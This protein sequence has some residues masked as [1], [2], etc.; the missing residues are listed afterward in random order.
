MHVP[1]KVN[2]HGSRTSA[3]TVL[4]I[5]YETGAGVGICARRAPWL[6]GYALRS[7][8]VVLPIVTVDCAKVGQISP[9]GVGPGCQDSMH[10]RRHGRKAL[11]SHRGGDVVLAKA[12]AHRRVPGWRS[13]ADYRGTFG[14][15]ITASSASSTFSSVFLLLDHRPST[16]AFC[17]SLHGAAIRS[18]FF[19]FRSSGHRHSF[20]T[21]TSFAR[22]PL[23]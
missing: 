15:F 21:R 23:R 3:Q 18:S 4:L 12:M 17:P 6:I 19:A 7:I 1:N 9:G 13:W 22:G 16:L 11:S 2:R 14:S 10:H 20:R 8:H 5:S